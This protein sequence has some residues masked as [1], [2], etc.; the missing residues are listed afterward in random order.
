MTTK[1]KKLINAFYGKFTWSNFLDWSI[2]VFAGLITALLMLSLGGVRPEAVLLILPLFVTII[3]LHG[4]SFLANPEDPKKLNPVPFYF[5]PL[6]IWIGLSVQWFSPVP[7]IG[8]YELIGALLAFTILWMVSNHLR[9][10]SHMWVFF[11]L[12][13]L[14]AGYGLYSGFSQFF[15]FPDRIAPSLS[16]EVIKLAP[17]F[18]GKATGTFA[19]PSS[20]SVVLLVLLPSMLILGVVGRAKKVS[21][22]LC[23]YICAMLFV[24]LILAQQLW[25]AFLVP[26]VAYFV[27]WFS[28][29]KLSKRLIVGTLCACVALAI[30]YSFSYMHSRIG[31]SYGGALSPQG[32]L[33]RGALWGDAVNSFLSSPFVGSGAGSYGISSVKNVASGLQTIPE[34]PLNDYLLLLAEYGVVGLLLFLIPT[35]I[36]LACGY[37]RWRDLPYK[38]TS[39]L[40]MGSFMPKAKIVLAVSLT[41]VGVFLLSAGLTS[42]VYV[43]ALLVLAGGAFAVLARVS[44]GSKFLFPNKTVLKGAYAVL[45][46]ILGIGLYLFAAPRIE[47]RAQ[48]MNASEKLD[49]ILSQQVQVSG[50]DLLLDEVIEAYNTALEKD[51]SNVDAMLGL[52]V[53]SAQLYY[54]DPLNRY[55]IATLAKAPLE[56]ALE[57]NKGYWK[58]WTQMGIIEAMNGDFE[59]AENAFKQGLTLAPNSVEANYYWAAY[60]YQ[61]PDKYELSIEAIERA[62]EISP[63]HSPSLLLQKK[64]L[65][66]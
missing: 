27:S 45:M 51:P 65:M 53:A 48:T 40:V 16:E 29:R 34:S 1:R 46:L 57:L 7:W 18:M 10:W 43:P 66:L 17:Q 38:V 59:A 31:Q 32:E 64:L 54:R 9:M 50:S 58:V 13:V 5:L 61:F 42:L 20:F 12:C 30:G 55:A 25:V 56:R 24:G 37:K 4:L 26:L 63:K 33:I 22:A 41:T 23:F 39:E 15:Q 3:V 19:D 21:R 62:L 8:R 36:L 11:L 60:N 47:S 35:I 28:A 44:F 52:S 49:H 14:P 6:L 2:T